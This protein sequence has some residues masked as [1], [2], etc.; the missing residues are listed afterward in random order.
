MGININMVEEIT[1]SKEVRDKLL[2]GINKA[3]KAV[4]ATLGPNGKTVIISDSDKPGQYKVTKDGVSVIN[5]IVLKDPI[6]N[7]GVQ[8]LREAAN[9]TVN[10]AG[11]GPQPL[12]SK[13]LT[14]NGFVKISNLRVDDDICGTNKSIQKVIGIYPKGKLKIYKLKFSNGQTVECSENHIWNVN[15]SYGSNK[16]LTTKELLNKGIKQFNKYGQCRYNFYTPNTIV[17]FSKKEQILDP[18]LVGLL[19]GDGSLCKT[20]SI[21]L[22][23]ALDQKYILDKIILPKG[24][25]MLY[26][27]DL[28]KHYLRVKF[29][30]IENSGP[31]MHDYIEQIGLLNCKS[32]DKFIPDNY[33]YSDYDSRIKLLEGLTETDGHVNKRGLLEYSTISKKLFNDVRELL[34]S[35]GKQCLGYLKE[36][37]LNSSYSNTSIYK[38]SELQGYK[39]GIKLID[40]IETSHFEEMMCI[41]V[42]NPDSLYVTNDYILTHNTTT[43]TVLTTAFI[44]NLKDFNTVDINK[45]FDEIIPKVIKQLKLNSRKLENEDIKYV[46]SISANNDMEIGNIIQSAYNHT[47]IVKVEESKNLE[48]TLELVNGMSLPVSFFSKHFITDKKKGICEF[49][50]NVFVL[51]LDTKLEK[52]ENFKSQLEQA[53]VSDCSLLIITEDVHELA[54]RKLESLVLSMDLPVCVIKTPGF[55]KHRKDLLQ[56]LSKFTGAT[57]IT[58]VNKSYN[59]SILGKLDSCKITKNNSI[60]VKHADIN[61]NEIIDNLKQQSE[62]DIPQHDI[63]LLKQR[64]EYL[65]GKVSIIKVGGGSELEMKERKDRYDDAVLAVACALEEGIV[66]GGGVALKVIS[67]CMSF[68]QKLPEVEWQIY[69]S[70]YAP[71]RIIN[72]GCTMDM[73]EQN[74]IDPLK[75]TRCAL[76]NAVSI[77]KVILSTEAVVLNVNEWNQN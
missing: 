70:L 12:Y 31:T 66:E 60:L 17:D 10:Q 43:A 23:L 52:L 1:F 46:A 13:V 21:E 27:E 33:K 55:S 67:N 39:N 16:N 34:N 50:N 51:L 35:L 5:S 73:F 71:S 62:S 64:I 74:I 18:F 69:N 38:I 57:I 15:T 19:L 63:D 56:D 59:N 29:S 11:D 49:T 2:S 44:N 14:P 65:E 53:Q 3:C 68:E 4:S 9:R 8:L 30:R 54:L 25:K 6:E 41:K 24:I 42:S 36:R 76:E 48:D 72:S 37:K 45:A 75:V 58:D 28:V 7:I 40:I 77:A 32:N 47:N 26:T 61:V 22:S 20:G